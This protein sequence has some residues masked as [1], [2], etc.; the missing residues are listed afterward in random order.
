MQDT[1]RSVPCRPQSRARACRVG[2]AGHGA[3]AGFGTRLALYPA[4][5]IL[6]LLLSGC[7][8]GYYGQAIK[9]HFSLMHQRQPVARVVADPATPAPV[10][11]QLLLAGDVLE[12]AGREL[13]LP[14]EDVYRTYVPLD[15]D[16]VVW[17][18]QAAPRF[19]L[20]PKTW[21]YPLV[22]CLSY[23][24]YFRE[25]AARAE[26]DRLA[27][28]GWD[29]DV[30]GAIAYSTLGWFEDPLTTPM[31]DRS[32][33]S[34]V[35]LVLHELVHRRLYIRDDT[36]FNES[37]ATMVAREG[38]LRY[39]AHHDLKVDLA[40]WRQR[41]R[42]RDAFLALVG[43]ARDD[44]ARLYA[45]DLDEA[46]MAAAKAA[47]IEALR[48]DVRARAEQ[49][50]GLDAYAGFFQGDLNNARLNGVHDY[51]GLVGTFQKILLSCGG[52]WPCFWER[53]KALARDRG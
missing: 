13:A 28:A 18:V 10:R 16:A 3:F 24:G 1:A 23:R 12:F 35:E 26:A 49:V 43:E 38:T 11:R 2:G 5:C 30:G 7:Q 27:R 31:I 15:R 48:R 47:R 9:G 46:T 52:Q 21:C 42:A 44:L 37:L 25:E 19:S 20:T 33:P 36:R 32:G 29:T 4:A 41:D 6:Y 53:V 51:Y 8:V 34:L 39:L 17:N 40:W 45:G 22:G 14:A 50:P